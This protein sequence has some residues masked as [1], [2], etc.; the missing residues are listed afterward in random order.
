MSE[1]ERGRKG[2]RDRQTDRKWRNIPYME[3]TLP[4]K[5]KVL[6]IEMKIVM[7]SHFLL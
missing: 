5:Y 2:G 3:V 4:Q 6:P 1:R 7:L